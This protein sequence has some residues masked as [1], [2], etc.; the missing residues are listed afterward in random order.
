M[1]ARI[2][3]VSQLT[4]ADTDTIVRG[5]GGVFC[6]NGLNFE[7]RFVKLFHLKFKEKSALKTHKNKK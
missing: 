3:A 6:Q 4:K 1:R 2:A 5:G 7:Q